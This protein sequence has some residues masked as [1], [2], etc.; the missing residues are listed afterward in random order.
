MRRRRRQARRPGRG[1]RRGAARAP[2][3]LRN[4]AQDNH[5]A[6][7]SRNHRL[8]LATGAS[9]FLSRVHASRREPRARRRGVLLSKEL[10]WRPSQVGGSEHHRQA[11]PPLVAN[12]RDPHDLVAMSRVERQVVPALVRRPAL[13]SLEHDQQPYGP[14]VRHLVRQPPLASP[15]ARLLE[16]AVQIEAVDVRV[17]CCTEAGMTR[18]SQQ[19]PCPPPERTRGT[20]EERFSSV[21][22]PGRARRAAGRRRCGSVRPEVLRNAGRATPESTHERAPWRGVPP[23]DRGGSTLAQASTGETS[24]ERKDTP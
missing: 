2:E 7:I 18:P 9:L 3:R 23:R 1:G 14:P 20:A 12:D 11:A 24:I 10:H 19:G 13:E 17:S 8:G 15:R 22:Q 6:V 4:D 21:E 5:P 16:Q